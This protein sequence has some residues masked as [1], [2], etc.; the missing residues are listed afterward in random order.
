[1][2]AFD[3]DA[4]YRYHS[5]RLL[6]PSGQHRPIVG[7]TGNYAEGS[8]TLAEGYY[9]SLLRA[10]ALPIVLPPLDA[11]SDWG[12]LL[13]ELDG[14]L[15][16]GGADVNPLWVN[17]EPLPTLGGINP[18][19]DACELLLVRLAADRQLPIFGICRGMQVI[20]AALGGK[21][22]QDLATCLGSTLSVKHNQSAPRSEA[23][24]RVSI[25]PGSRLHT[26]LGDSTTV[27]SFHHQAVACCGT[28]L[29]P[30]A[31]SAD[32]VIEA[33]ESS[34]HK[35]I[36]AV[37]WHPECMAPETM[38]AL[39]EH[40]VAEA[41]AYRRARQWHAQHLSLDSHCDTPMFFD[42]GIDF[43]RR[44]PQLLVDSHK[45]REGG[46]DASI[47]V[48]YL[49]Q[50][51][52]DEEHHAKAA[53]QATTLLRRL[54]SMV[55]ACPTAALGTCEADISRHKAE[56]KNTILPGIENGYAFGHDLAQV[57]RFAR[58]GVVY[59]TLCHNGNNDICDSARPSQHD[60][61]H[62]PEGVEHGGLSPFG[63]EVI[64]EMN[65]V[66]MLVDLSHA[67][68][69]S[70][71]QAI[72]CSQVPIVCSH[73]SARA[74]CNHPRNLTDH[75]L[76]SLAAAGG[77][78]QCT[79]YAGFLREESDKADVRDALRHLLHMIDVAGIA[80]VG[81]GTDF[82]GDGGVPGLESASA[83]L[84]LTQMLQAEGLTDA[85][86]AMIW[87][88]NFLRVLHTAQQHADAQLRRSI[89]DEFYSLLG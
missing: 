6:A 71:Y 21:V 16:S 26:L 19:R 78:A 59:T 87:G 54:H 65:R 49:P 44:D 29:R 11:Q 79:F 74:L 5:E 89:L 51:Q 36:L 80:H 30:T 37:Q 15:F 33:L 27:N 50:S 81:I 38:S 84:R 56:G 13:D 58:M 4:L 48:A 57:E 1:M 40:F 62:F 39:F 31:W 53:Q 45:M 72:E 23:T 67:A 9:E 10:G 61:S 43:N 46:L 68:E 20:A 63:R 69:S 64:G 41:T 47:M 22:Y 32:G 17:E 8:C 34:Q 76:R 55:Q 2:N 73:S 25:E 28:Q 14:L 83:L 7:I 86:L 70:F 85:D 60:K 18:K 12:T 3:L 66:G 88:G 52:R 82:D 75:Q 24:H 77:V 42:K 35:S